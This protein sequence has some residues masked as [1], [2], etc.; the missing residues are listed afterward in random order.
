MGL[1]A[2]LKAFGSRFLVQILPAALASLAGGFLFSPFHAAPPPPVETSSPAQMQQAMARLQDEHDAVN[3]LIE[4]QQMAEQEKQADRAKE[5]ELAREE[6]ANEA[7]AKIA[8]AAAAREAAQKAAAQRKVV[9]AG[10]KPVVRPEPH[11]EHLPE[12]AAA[13]P[14]AG[15][16]LPITPPVAVAPKR[17]P[18][19]SVIVTANHLTDRTL[20]AAD[21][22]RGFFVSAANRIVDGV[23]GRAA[24]SSRLTSSW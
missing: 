6:A 16:P 5:L 11:R 20:A 3:R 4:R 12:T 10:V 23:S 24:P 15:T 14:A 18:I 21:A 19:D 9:E 7:R 22:V 17:G 13:E 8:A 1:R 2:Y